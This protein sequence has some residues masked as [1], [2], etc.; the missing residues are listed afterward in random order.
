[1]KYKRNRESQ[2]EAIFDE[3]TFRSILKFI[4]CKNSKLS[5]LTDGAVDEEHLNQG[6]FD[7]GYLEGVRSGMEIGQILHGPGR[8]RYGKGYQTSTEHCSPSYEMGNLMGFR[9]GYWIATA[10]QNKRTGCD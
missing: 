5:D 4:L 2:N 6:D 1:M 3:R 8:K 10:D 9:I 7:R